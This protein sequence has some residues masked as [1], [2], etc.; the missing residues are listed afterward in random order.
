[1]CSFSFAGPR[2][3]KT[4]KV[5]NSVVSLHHRASAEE[6]LPVYVELQPMAS[7]CAATIATSHHRTITGGGCGPQVHLWLSLFAPHPGRHGVRRSCLQMAWHPILWPVVAQ[8]VRQH[9]PGARAVPCQALWPECAEQRLLLLVPSPARVL[10]LVVANDL[11]HKA[12]AEL[13]QNGFRRMEQQT[14]S[15]H[16]HSLCCLVLGQLLTSR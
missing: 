7:K 6:F 10:V 3:A 11:Y 12:I 13:G 4:S 9:H 14:R 15:S 1:M 2:R 16:M 5:H 8:A